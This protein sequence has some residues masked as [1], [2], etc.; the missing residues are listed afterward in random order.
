MAV[1][2]DFDGILI[3]GGGLVGALAALQFAQLGFKVTL[4]EKREDWREE[5]RKQSGAAAAAAAL[6]GKDATEEELAELAS[7]QNAV[8]RR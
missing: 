1:Y 4:V 6:V 7:A 8:K 5:E 3:A 2:E